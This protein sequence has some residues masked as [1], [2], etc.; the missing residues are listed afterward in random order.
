MFVLLYFPGPDTVIAADSLLSWARDQ[1]VKLR[2]TEK[3]HNA[4]R[5]VSVITLLRNSVK[6]YPNVP[7]LGK[8]A[9]TDF[10]CFWYLT[11]DLSDTT[12]VL[13]FYSEKF[14][15]SI[16]NFVSVCE[17]FLKMTCTSAISCSNASLILLSYT[18]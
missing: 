2:M 16:W 9:G 13:L 18:S 14:V 8:N 1:P 5:P 3:G 15:F 4:D 11:I 10:R 6:Q 7:A 17:E 12:N